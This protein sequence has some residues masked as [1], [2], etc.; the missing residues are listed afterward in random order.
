MAACSWRSRHRARGRPGGVRVRQHGL[1]RD[2]RDVR[3]APPLQHPLEHAGAKVRHDEHLPGSGAA[4]GIGRARQ[5]AGQRAD[6]LT[7][8][9]RIDRL[10]ADAEPQAHDLHSAELSGVD[11]IGE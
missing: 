2:G 11:L 9:G 10:H 1:E 3:G 8:I 5:H 6:R 7:E 4:G